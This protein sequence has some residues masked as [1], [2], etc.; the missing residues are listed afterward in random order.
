[1]WIPS[2]LRIRA[3]ETIERI[4]E[5]KQEELKRLEEVGSR[6]TWIPQANQLAP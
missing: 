5:R 6:K 4:R 3:K 2:R 1:M